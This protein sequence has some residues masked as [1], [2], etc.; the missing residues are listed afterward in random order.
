MPEWAASDN[1]STV[2]LQASGRSS[3]LRRST[4][5]HTLRTNYVHTRLLY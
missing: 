1:G 3:I 2:A 4:T 5:L